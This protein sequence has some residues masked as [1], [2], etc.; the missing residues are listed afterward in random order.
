MCIRPAGP[1]QLYPTVHIS[2]ILFAANVFIFFLKNKV[3]ATED[4]VSQCVILPPALYIFQLD[5][6]LSMD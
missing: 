5:I 2:V 4:C 6:K 3:M 1:P